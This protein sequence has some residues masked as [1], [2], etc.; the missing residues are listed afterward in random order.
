M[1][2]SRHDHPCSPGPC[3]MLS[4]TQPALP[5][6]SPPKPQRFRLSP[7][8][9]ETQNRESW[10]WALATKW[11][12]M[13]PGQ[14]PMATKEL[15]PQL[16]HPTA[17]GCTLPGPPL[18]ILQVSSQSPPRLLWLPHSPLTPTL[19]FCSVLR[20]YSWLRGPLSAGTQT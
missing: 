6:G 19:F 2:C 9:C 7:K 1:A 13:A 5:E 18:K 17:Q 15:Y 12:R 10:Q 14:M 3:Y 20:C 8:Q 4:A 11:D 16:P